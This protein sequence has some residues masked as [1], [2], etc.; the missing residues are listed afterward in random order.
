MSTV[1]SPRTE[2]FFL[3][4]LAGIQFS[5]IL[6]FM[7]MMPLGPILMRAFGIET[8]QFG[9]L[10]AS[11]SFSAAI[12]GILAA[13]FID[14]F[15]RKRMLLICFSLF[16]LATLACGVAPGYSTL[17]L[18]RG[19]AGVFGG[20]MG[21]MIHTMI[22]DAIPFSR[23][24]RASGVVSSAFSISTI[25]GVPLS[26]WLANNF[27]WRAP[28]VLI[29][30]LSVFF[31]VVGE[32]F[33]PELR[34]HL[35][36]EKRAHLLSA[37][38]SV[39]AD[40]N[41]LR[42]LLF[43]SLLIFSGFTVIPYITIYA[44]NNVGIAQ[45]DIPI[46]YLVGGTATFISARLIGRWA[47]KHGKVDV[48]RWLALLAM[49]PLLVLTHIGV[50]PL[51]G[52]LICSTSFFLLISGRMIPA[53]AIIASSAQPKL[54]GTFMSLNSTVQSLA[55]GLGSTLAG[56]LTTLDESGRIVGYPLVGYVAVV[57]NLVAIWFVSRIDMHGRN[58]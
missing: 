31:L 7:I 15:E 18:A 55:M 48:Y 20:I 37:T 19:L 22:A 39:L 38:F 24:A 8:H 57:A 13:T 32:R 30:L 11:Y 53:M 52:W 46:I 35:G 23:R 49:A 42:A 29:A 2:R 56:F 6:D 43:S 40:A 44:V 3:L 41:H 17:M 47:D 4:T 28:F 33:L 58:L 1:L 25:A 14:L 9:L 54:R 21:A 10:V 27:G 5:H 34:H 12:S 16:A 51:W 26:L 50:V 45:Q 36:E